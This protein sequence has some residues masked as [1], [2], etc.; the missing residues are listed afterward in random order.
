M[1]KPGVIGPGEYGV[2]AFDNGGYAHYDSCNSLSW[3]IHGPD[4][5][6][7]RESET[8]I[9]RRLNVIYETYWK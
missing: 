9:G 1:I 8:N 7:L 4:N 3:Q 6:P 5:L 2:I